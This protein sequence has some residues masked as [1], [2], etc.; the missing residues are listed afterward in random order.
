[1]SDI[2]NTGFFTPPL[3]EGVKLHNRIIAAQQ[4]LAQPMYHGNAYWQSFLLAAYAWLNELNVENEIRRD[5][6]WLADGET[7]QETRR[8]VGV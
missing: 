3:P 7:L 8:L 6:D 5:L 4:I 2:I 1:M